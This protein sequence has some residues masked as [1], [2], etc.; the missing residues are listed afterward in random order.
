MSVVD[1]LINEKI[2]YEKAL[3]KMNVTADNLEKSLSAIEKII[4]S[5]N[6][7]YTIEGTNASGEYLNNLYERQYKVYTNIVNNIVPAMNNKI[8]N[9]EC[10]IYTAREAE[11]G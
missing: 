8:Y 6:K 1:S 10:N 4:A 2:A 11:N 9:I 7:F 5:E 3:N